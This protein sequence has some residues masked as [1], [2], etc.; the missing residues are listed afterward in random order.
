MIVIWKAYA[1]ENGITRVEIRAGVDRAR[2]HYVG[3]L[4]FRDREWEAL[5]LANVDD[6]I[7]DETDKP[8]E[9]GP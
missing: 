2:A 5:K 9:F 3:E 8:K 6:V 4:Q 1:R 7:V